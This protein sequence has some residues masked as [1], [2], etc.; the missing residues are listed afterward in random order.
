MVVPTIDNVPPL[1]LNVPSTFPEV[2]FLVDVPY[3]VVKQ[4]TEYDLFVDV[5]N[6]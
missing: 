2:V 6:V 3:P 5:V 4:L 1:F